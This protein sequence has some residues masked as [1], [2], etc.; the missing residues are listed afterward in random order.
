LSWLIGFYLSLKFQD[1]KRLTENNF[2]LCSGKTQKTSHGKLAFSDWIAAKIN[3]VAGLE[4]GDGHIPLLVGDIEDYGINIATMT[5]DLSSRRPYKLPLKN[6]YH[7]FKVDEFQVLFPDWILGHLINFS[8]KLASARKL[9]QKDDYVPLPKGYHYFIYGPETPLHLVVRMSLSFPFLISAIP[10]YRVDYETRSEDKGKLNVVKPKYDYLK[11]CTFSDGGISSNFPIHFFD[12]LLPNR[13]TFGVTLDSNKRY[14]SEA[15][16]NDRIKI[17]D[18]G[19]NT[20]ERRVEVIPSAAGFLSSLRNTSANWKDNLQT[21]LHGYAERIVT[22]RLNSKSEGGINLNMPKQTVA[23]LKQYGQDAGKELVRKFHQNSDAI[24]EH[25]ERRAKGTLIAIEQIL[26]N[27]SQNY[28]KSDT[29][30]KNWEGLFNLKENDFS[31]EQIQLVKDLVK[32]GGKN[33]SRMNASG[34]AIGR[35]VDRDKCN[36]AIPDAQL[37]YTASADRVI[38]EFEAHH[39]NQAQ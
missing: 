26:V 20:E 13:L 32:L 37:R 1:I 2:G 27:F 38:A 16:D 11:K 18:H 4:Y 39:S 15:Y 19:F 7:Y 36:K 28:N 22:I 8:D 31:K 12:S 24:N 30:D 10:L 23:Q 6:R 9:E 17:R 34:Q 33:F 14:K 29:W 21:Q 25:R 5:S 3:T 35:I